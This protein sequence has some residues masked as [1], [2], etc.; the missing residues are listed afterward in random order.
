MLKSPWKPFRWKPLLQQGELDFSPA[1]KRSRL[2]WALAAGFS[3]ASAKAH[4]QSR[5]FFPRINA[6]APTQ[7]RTPWVLHGAFQ[8]PLKPCPFKA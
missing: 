6:G 3:E 4:D 7:K 5:S 1:E 2:K 8:Q